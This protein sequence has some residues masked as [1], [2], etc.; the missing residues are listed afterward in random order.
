MCATFSSIVICRPLSF[1]S[2]EK[3]K[4]PRVFF[5]FHDGDRCL[6]KLNGR[7]EMPF[8]LSTFIYSIEFGSPVETMFLV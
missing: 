5:F 8:H 7:L 3:K 6:A 2:P 4:Q 1:L